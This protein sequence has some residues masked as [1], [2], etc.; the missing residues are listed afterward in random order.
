MRQR[1]GKCGDVKTEHLAPTAPLAHLE[2]KVLKAKQSPL[3]ETFVHG[4]TSLTLQALF[5]LS[6]VLTP[7]PGKIS[8]AEKKPENRLPFAR[9]KN[10]LVKI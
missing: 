5:S 2:R 7:D 6:N 9:P 1:A 10:I 3:E 8:F 4:H